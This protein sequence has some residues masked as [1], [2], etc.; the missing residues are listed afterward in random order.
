MLIEALA[1]QY[2][3][4]THL[5]GLVVPLELPAEALQFAAGQD[6]SA[7]LVLELVPLLP[8][9]ALLPLQEPQLLLFP[10]TL[11]QLWTMK[12]DVLYTL[13][14]ITASALCTDLGSLSCFWLTT[15]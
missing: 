10:P 15:D 1:E 7:V 5:E 9:V 12:T 3:V 8:H 14:W 4:I 6:G 13:H 11:L 2:A